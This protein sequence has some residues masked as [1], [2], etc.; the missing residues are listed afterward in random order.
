LLK[1]VLT[2]C[3]RERWPVLSMIVGIHGEHLAELEKLFQGFH[4]EMIV[5]SDK[6][7]RP[8]MYYKVDGHWNASGHVFVAESILNSL[9]ARGLPAE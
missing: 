1:E 5:V 4:V 2:I 3:D 8:D 9:L 7:T 6:P